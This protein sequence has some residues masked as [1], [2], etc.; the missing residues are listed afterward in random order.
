[1]KQRFKSPWAQRLAA[2]GFGVLTV[3]AIYALALGL[4]DDIRL[5]YA[6]GAVFLFGAAL[7]LGRNKQDWFAVGLLVAPLVAM[8]SYE[9]LKKIPALWP[10]LLL[11]IVAAA[12]GLVLIKIVRKQIALAVALV[13]ALFIGSA[14]YCA[15]Y[16][17]ERLE[18]SFSRVKNASSQTFSLQPVSNGSVPV[19]SKSGRILVID[20][21][22]TTCAPCIAELPEITAVRADLANNHDIEFVLVAS[23]KG[24]DTPE[25]FRSFAQRRGLSLPLAFDVDGK[26]HDGFGLTGVPALVVLDRTGRVRFT[27]EGYNPAERNFRK[28]LVQFLKTL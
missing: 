26:A 8:F 6:S 22:S 25:R 12:V 11:W 1:M 23:E 5:I 17:P 7:W 24:N 15:W 13:A 20:F 9:V 3:I 28:D 14:W 2:L 16:V 27:H 4:S 10:A 19:S 21:F 18:R